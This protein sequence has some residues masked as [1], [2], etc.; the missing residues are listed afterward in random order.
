MTNTSL[1]Y[2]Y[3]ETITGWTGYINQANDERLPLNGWTFEAILKETYKGQ[4]VKRLDLAVDPENDTYTLP[5]IEIDFPP[6]TY[7]LEIWGTAPDEDP[8]YIGTIEIIVE[9]S[10]KQSA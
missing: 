6:K 10:N 7:H 3:G 9:G 2:K 8:D 4:E 5:K 1:T